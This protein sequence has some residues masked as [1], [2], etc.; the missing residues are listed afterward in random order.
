M[1]PPPATILDLIISITIR[2]R[3]RTQYTPL[4]P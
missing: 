1:A 2:Y 3:P 4:K